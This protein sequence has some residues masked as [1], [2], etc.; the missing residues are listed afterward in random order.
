MTQVTVKG[1]ETQ[2]LRQNESDQVKKLRPT[3]FYGGRE[4]CQGK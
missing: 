4:A 2:F 3:Y 1:N